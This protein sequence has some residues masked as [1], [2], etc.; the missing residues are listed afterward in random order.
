MTNVATIMILNETAELRKMDNSCE[1][2]DKA[3]VYLFDRCK[4]F[5]FMLVDLLC[6]KNMR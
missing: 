4:I 3:A 6:V 5:R 1:N 2:A